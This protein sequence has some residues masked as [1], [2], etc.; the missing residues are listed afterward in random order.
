MSFTRQMFQKA[1]SSQVRFFKTVGKSGALW[2]FPGLVTAGWLLWPALDQEWLQSLGLASDPDA[3]VKAV[4]AAK[5]AEQELERLQNE[6]Q[7][8][9]AGMSTS[10]ENRTLPE[11]I[12]QAH[13]DSKNAE[14]KVEQA[15][16]KLK[17]LSKELKVR[18]A[19]IFCLLSF[20]LPSLTLIVC[21]CWIDGSYTP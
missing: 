7:T 3:V 20:I 15:K 21:F 8:M 17:H 9:S 19:S 12:S 10:S 13:A 18:F 16:L 4:Q 2:A 14:S 5:E 6:Y 1:M 11:Q